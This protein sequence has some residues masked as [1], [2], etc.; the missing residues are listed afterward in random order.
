MLTEKKPY[1]LGIIPARGGS[2]RL[3]RKNVKLLGGRPLIDYVIKTGGQCDLIN[4][5]I[6]STD[7][8]EIKQVALS[9]GVNVPFLRPKEL[10]KDS[11]TLSSL[12]GF[13]AFHCCSFFVAFHCSSLSSTV[14]NWCAKYW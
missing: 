2:K 8:K 5:L 12:C 3:S 11:S 14:I 9:C 6:V 10:A 1:I 7:D 13:V 4:E